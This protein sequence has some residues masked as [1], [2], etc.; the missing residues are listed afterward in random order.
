MAFIFH[1]D[2]KQWISAC[3]RQVQVIVTFVLW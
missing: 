1:K 3:V 2:I